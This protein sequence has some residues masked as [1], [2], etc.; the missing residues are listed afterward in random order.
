M[1]VQ[2]IYQNYIRLETSLSGIGGVDKNL[3]RY[4]ASCS[5]SYFL[6]I[7]TLLV[8]QEY[9][10]IEY[11]T[12]SILGFL[13]ALAFHYYTAILWVFDERRFPPGLEGILFVLISVLYLPMTLIPM[14]F[15]IEVLHWH[16]MTSKLVTVI[17]VFFLNYALKKKVLFTAPRR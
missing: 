9:L 1:S 15:F 14:S 2:K 12:A 5:V 4:I 13:L 6:D 16:Y 11:I 3:I 10:G 17:I 8:C 7:G